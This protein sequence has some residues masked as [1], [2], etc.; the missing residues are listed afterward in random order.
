M[1]VFGAPRRTGSS[2][3]FKK[4]STYTTLDPLP[5]R[6]NVA[7]NNSTSMLSTPIQDHQGSYQKFIIVMAEVTEEEN[8]RPASS[9]N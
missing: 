3:R 1:K 8:R 7:N 9:K 2:L 4:S 6:G 5:H